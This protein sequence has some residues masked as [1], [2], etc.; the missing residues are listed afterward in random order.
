M[1]DD[2]WIKDKLISIDNKI[3]KLD[4]R[5]DGIDIT[6]ATQQLSLNEHMKRSLHLEEEF[7]PI[8]AQQLQLTG[9]LKLIAILATLLSILQMMKSFKS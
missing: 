2:Q 3:D 8:R 9:G 1:H 4:S 6:L 7:K 5:V